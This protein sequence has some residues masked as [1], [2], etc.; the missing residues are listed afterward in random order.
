MRYHL[1]R[2]EEQAL[3]QHNLNYQRMSQLGEQLLTLFEKPEGTS[4]TNPDGGQWMTL[5]DISA[6]LKKVFK[7]AYSED[8]GVY[9]RIGNFLSRPECKFENARRSSGR[10]YWVKER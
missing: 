8:E 10:V 6:R 3:M 9:V 1:T 7:G 5:K 4:K 2:E